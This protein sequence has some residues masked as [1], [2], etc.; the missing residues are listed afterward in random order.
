MRLRAKANG[1]VHSLTY[2]THDGHPRRTLTLVST[3]SRSG[4]S[5][6][7]LVFN[8]KYA[9]GESTM[10]WPYSQHRRPSS[11]CPN[12][13]TFLGVYG[14]TGYTTHHDALRIVGIVF[15]K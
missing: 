2:S 14:W 9:V 4:C 12:G 1:E 10:S 11:N 5:R 3:R 6:G 15:S 13:A 8:L 7:E